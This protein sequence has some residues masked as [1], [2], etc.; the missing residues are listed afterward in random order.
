MIDFPGLLRALVDRRVQFI[1][2]GGAAATAHG[3]ARLTQDLDIVY[4]RRPE[5]LAN[6][7][8]ALAHHEPYLRGAPP[9]LPFTLDVETLQNGLNF[10][11]TSKLGDID[12]LGEIVGGGGYEQLVSDS[13]E[14][15]L[16]GIRCLCL[17]LEK[18]IQVKRAAGR[19]KD[20]E[21]LAEL[22]SILDSDE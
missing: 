12:L 22:E 20:F 11:L 3:A 6:L 18:L 21:V 4:S 15:E 13:I 8:A 1:I 5:N 16:F 7:V 10:T 2:V 17:G 14:I 9:D 19:P